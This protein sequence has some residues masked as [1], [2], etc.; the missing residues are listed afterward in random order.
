MS[1]VRYTVLEAV[2]AGVLQHLFDTSWGGGGPVYRDELNYSL[3]WVCAHIGAELVAFVNIAWDGGA[4]AFIVDTTVHPDHRHRGIGVELVRL[5]SDAARDAGCEW[6][7][8]D[9]EP[10]LA[11]FYAACGFKETSAGLM[12]L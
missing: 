1:D 5:A 10:Q 9:F 3:T 7:H 11:R 12:R 8:V 4:H 6:L 2:D